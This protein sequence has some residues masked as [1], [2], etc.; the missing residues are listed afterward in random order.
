MNRK[1]LAAVVVILVIAIAIVA[2]FSVSW[3]VA[4]AVVKVDPGTVQ[5]TVDEDFAVNITVSSVQDLYG[6]EFELGW[7]SSVLG[8]SS[9]T[10]GSFLKSRAQTFF[11]YNASASYVLLDCSLLGNVTGVSGDGVLASIQLHVNGSGSCDLALS[12]V[13]L[14]NSAEHAMGSTADSGYFSTGS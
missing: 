1:I 14:I 8:F 2:Y 11:T 9:V 5:K 4:A 13:Q 6:W 7:N 12:D 3:P 10:E